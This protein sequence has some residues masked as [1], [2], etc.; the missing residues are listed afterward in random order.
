MNLRARLQD[1]LP[2][3]PVLLVLASLSA[4]AQAPAPAAG[5]NSGVTEGRREY[6][7]VDS[8]GVRTGKMA[9]YTGEF[10][11]GRRHGRGMQVFERDDGGEE[12][13]VGEW[14]EDQR[15]GQGTL[16]T[17]HMTYVGQ[18]E[19]NLRH[20]RGVET[21]R[22]GGVYEGEFANGRRNGQGMFRWPNGDVYEG[23]WVDNV[24]VGQ[25]TLKWA[26]GDVY[27]GEWL[28]GQRTGQ[29]FLQWT[30]GAQYEGGFLD[31]KMHGFGLYVYPTGLIQAEYFLDNK[32]AMGSQDLRQLKDKPAGCNG[33][34]ADWVLLRGQC[35][36]Q[37]L[38]AHN[39]S[40]PLLMHRETY[41]QFS[42]DGK[43]SVLMLI[44]QGVTISGESRVPFEFVTA[45]VRRSVM[46]APGQTPTWVDEYIGPMRGLLMHGN[47]RCAR[48]GGG[49]EPCVMNEGVR[50]Q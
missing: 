49:L 48:Q 36:K 15:W 8:K 46:L 14:R 33:Q 17:P 1:L 20:G 9:V 23:Q 19:K 35:T 3:L 30:S 43:Q 34:Y 10:L 32:R 41:D 26:S 42:F 5:A 22:D 25:G 39:G 29:G 12:S 13:Y 47:G 40:P 24:R 6:P 31:G 21:Y 11:N 2:V 37:G 27:E 16:K 44:R 18:F 45:Q 4:A 38:R 7:V 50:V 28:N